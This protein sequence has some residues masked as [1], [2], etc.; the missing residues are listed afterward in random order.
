[1]KQN[2]T[3]TIEVPVPIGTTVYDKAFPLY[4]HC[5]VGYRIGKMA[6]EDADEYLENHGLDEPYMELESCCITS[7]CPISEFGTSIFL[8][9][10]EAKRS[11]AENQEVL[12]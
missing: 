9:R 11:A 3:I 6:G 5:V 8:T 1:M 4:P 10:D 12:G 2:Q 7:S